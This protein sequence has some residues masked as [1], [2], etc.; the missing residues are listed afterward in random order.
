MGRVRELDAGRWARTRRAVFE[1][2]GRR[3]V[4]CGRPGRLECDHVVPLHRGGAPFDLDNLQTL[5]RRCHVEKSRGESTNDPERARWRAVL[6]EIAA[7][8]DGN[9]AG[10]ENGS[11]GG[12][13]LH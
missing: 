3:C 12:S 6:D 10:P 9:A 13:R 7:G 8:P 11:E 1:R 5:C 2:D 4:Q